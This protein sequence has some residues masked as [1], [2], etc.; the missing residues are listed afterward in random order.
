MRP[1]RRPARDRGRPLPGR[2]AGPAGGRGRSRAVGR[3][4]CDSVRQRGERVRA[5]VAEDVACGQPRV[6]RRQQLLQSQLGHR[7]G[8]GDGP[9]RPRPDLQRA[10]LL[11]MSFQGRPRSATQPVERPRARA[12]AAHQHRRCGRP[13]ATRAAATAGSCRTARFTASRPRARIRITHRPR[14]GALRGR[15]AVHAARTAVCDRRSRVRPAAQATCRSAHAW[16]PPS[17]ASA[18]SRPCPSGRS[19]RTPIRGTPTATAS[20]G[21][22]TASAASAPA[23]WRSGALAGRPTCRPSSSRTRG[24]STAT[25]ASRAPYSRA[26]NCSGGQDA[27]RSA[28]NGGRPE[29]DDRKLDRVTLYTRTLAVPARRDVGAADTS[30]GERTLHEAR[31]LVVPS[32]RAAH[33]RRPA[34]RARRA[35]HPAVHRSA[36]ARHGSGPRR[37]TPGRTR[38]QARNG[39]RRRCGA[40]A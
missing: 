35:G 26:E 27:C 38:D 37:R 2:R 21:A 4:G 36:P 31:L 3:T 7:A 29:I 11:L 32:S 16:L 14:A 12:A 13:A 1:R 5:A 19:S 39:A 15:H 22:P 18:C 9:R 6:R 33:R 30:A 40:S 10:V 20:P 28:R 34:R 25:S 8:I 24:R 23:A 17:S